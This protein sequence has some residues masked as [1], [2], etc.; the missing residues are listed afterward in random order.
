MSISVVSENFLGRNHLMKVFFLFFICLPQL[1]MAA[2]LYV[3]TGGSDSGSGT[4]S[5]PLRTIRKA[6]SVAKAG[7]TVHVAAGTYAETILSSA[8]GSASARIRFVS[9]TKWGAKITP[10]SGSTGWDIRG[11]YVTVEGF[12]LNCSNN[13][14]CKDGIY[15]GGSNVIIKGNHVHH[16]ATSGAC[17]NIG[18]SAI[19]ADAYYGGSNTDILENVV[20]HIGTATCAYI[21]GIYH[22]TTGSIKN[23]LVY[24]VGAVALHLWHDAHNIDIINNTAFSS[25]YGLVVGGGDFYHDSGGARNV[26]VNNNILFDNKY[27]IS[28]QGV[29]GSGNTYINNLVFQNSTYNVSLKTGSASGTLAANPQFINYIPAGGGDYHL[30][31]TSPAINKGTSSLAPSVDLDGKARPQGG[32]VDIGAY[33]FVSGTP[34]PQPAPTPAP[35]PAPA[36]APTPTPAPSPAPVPAKTTVNMLG[37]PNLSVAPGGTVTMSMRWNAAP[38]PANYTVFVHLVSANGTQYPGGDHAPSVPTSTW[39]GPISYNTSRLI[40]TSMPAGTYTIR[41]GLYSGAN[42]YAVNPGPGVSVDNETRYTVG[43]LTIG[44]GTPTPTP[45]PTPAPAPAPVPAPTPAPGNS[46]QLSATQVT[47]GQAITVTVNGPGADPAEW[48]ALYLASNPD[49]AYSH[50]STWMYLNGSK[51]IPTS[52]LKSATLKVIAPTEVGTYNIRFFAHAEYGQRIALS[53]NIKVVAVSAPAPTP[54]PAPRPAPG[55]TRFLKVNTTNILPGGDLIVTVEGPGANP[56]E[57]IALYAANKPDSAWSYQ[58]NWKYLN[59]TQNPPASP[60]KTVEITFKAPAAAGT[61]N[62]RFFGSTGVSQRLDI[63]PDITVAP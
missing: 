62:I 16:I 38:M 36:P 1:A 24:Q 11:S 32:A 43:T 30:K 4:A 6:S 31:S 28:E 37:T 55:R 39:N 59:G 14:S 12:E 41:V 21:Q 63:S 15:V 26:H 54:A 42:R 51:T 3:S 52:P 40:P 48:I 8:S 60:V 61:Y 35:A 33:E 46:L 27:G 19:N 5:S 7:D 25:G 56:T 13:S 45:T 53:A 10:T 29:T 18:G 20:H 34:T 17:T 47:P 44:N 50:K 23:N 58:G 49:S 9:D 57:W 22:S 2:D